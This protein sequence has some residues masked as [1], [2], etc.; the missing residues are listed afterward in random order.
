MIKFIL[1]GLI[2][3]RSRSLFP[4]L[5]VSAGAFLTVL[6]YSWITGAM[7]DIV[8]S[9]AQFNSGHVKITTRAYQE[10]ADQIPNDLAL[11][12]VTNLL[13]QLRN[14]EN[15][16]L[17]TPRIRFGGLIDIPDIHG[18]T[19]TQGPVMG[20]GVDLFSKNS[21][22]ITVLNLKNALVEGKLP[23]KKNEILISAEFA[24]KLGVKIGEP[25]TLLGSTMNGA[26]AMHNFTISGTLSFG[27]TALDRGAIIADITDVGFA[28][29][30]I[31]GASEIVGYSKNMV[32]FNT[33]MKELARD[34][35]E[36][37]SRKNDEFS[38]IMLTLGQQ[39]G[40]EEYLQLAGTFSFII[41]SV[42][43][44]VMSLVLWN[45]GLM[46]G[47]RRYG[48]IGVRLAMGESKGSLYRWMI[49]ESIIIG[50]VGSLLG[51]LVGLAISYYMQYHG[52]DFGNIM[53]KSSM[54]ISSVMRAR[55]TKGSYII[56][57]FPGLIASVI[58]TCFAGIGIYRRQ[59]A[60]LFKDLE[61]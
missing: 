39:N 53:Q 60:Q 52:I 36:K 32:Y 43:I 18:E 61:V 35:N 22:E 16:M 34:F 40:F 17:W 25:A 54:M 11:L 48:E 33:E 1:K 19:K 23:Q 27:I 10:L 21:P 31:D 7:G 51:T 57:F 46:N 44:F 24:K 6:L 49:F 15:K 30:M 56:G 5:M 4:V 3:D 12:G 37:F 9:T 59:T 8:N 55:V 38:P 20:L 26:M 50:L 41:V 29:D 47:I 14:N 42:F 2:R 13:T 45:S 28:L 58:G